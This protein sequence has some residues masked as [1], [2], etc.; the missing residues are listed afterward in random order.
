MPPKTKYIKS[1]VECNAL[2]DG[3]HGWSVEI[4]YVNCLY[5]TAENGFE[6]YY[7]ATVMM[8]EL[9]WRNDNFEAGTRPVN[10][11]GRNDGEEKLNQLLD[12]WANE[13]SVFNHQPV[14]H[15]STVRLQV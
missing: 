1:K 15:A 8:L 4:Y 5:Y 6:H 13:L 10:Y 2:R 14:S 9:R 7:D 12:E 11:Q 3:E